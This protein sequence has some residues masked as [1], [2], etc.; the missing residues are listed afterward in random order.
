LKRFFGNIEAQACRLPGVTHAVLDR[1]H[2]LLDK[3]EFY[4][5]PIALK[6]FFGDGDFT[7]VQIGAYIGDSSN[8]P[9][10]T[11]VKQELRK[12]RC[13]LICAEPVRQHFDTLVENYRGFP[14]VIFENMAIA[15]RTGQATLYR[16]GVDPIDYDYPEWLSQL[17]SLKKANGVHWGSI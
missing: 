8:D 10:F 2:K 3:P 17:S 9:L 6:A 7:L 11:A 13:R 14:N 4:P 5:I 1:L 15:E 16:L 12:G